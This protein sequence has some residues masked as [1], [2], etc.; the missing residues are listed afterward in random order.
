MR[1]RG[2]TKRQKLARL[3]GNAWN[4]RT[5]FTHGILRECICAYMYLYVRAFA[6]GKYCALRRPRGGPTEAILITGMP[7]EVRLR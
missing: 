1:K 5:H 4:V 6:S 3:V 7:R 2:V